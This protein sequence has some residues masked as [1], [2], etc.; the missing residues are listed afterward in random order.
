M[1]GRWAICLAKRDADS[2]GRLWRTAAVE[3][4]RHGDAIWLRGPGPDEATDRRL[5]CVA[6]ARRFTVLNDGQLLPVA[7]RVPHGR[8][9]EGPWVPLRQW[10]G[11]DLPTAAMAARPDARV[12]LRLVRSAAE[13]ET[14]ILLTTFDRF[15]DY[16]VAAPHVRLDCWSF[17]AAD[18]GRVLIRG[19]PLPP[20]PGERFV[21]HGGVAVPAGWT[22]SP[23]VDAPT[24]CRLLQLEA[25]DLALLGVDGTWQRIAGDDFVRAGRSAIRATA[26]GLADG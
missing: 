8:L 4:C 14:N 6:G 19:T 13:E 20:L 5:R 10:A 12:P 3:V 17:A 9:P 24:L 18:E 15:R 2:L 22:W 16:A 21:D 26:E 7:A 25:N 11:L 23:A 1:S